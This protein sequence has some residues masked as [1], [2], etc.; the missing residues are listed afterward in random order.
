MYFVVEFVSMS[1]HTMVIQHIFTNS[2]VKFHRQFAIDVDIFIFNSN[3]SIS[4]S[5]LPF[6]YISQSQYNT[7]FSRLHISLQFYAFTFSFKY[8]MNVTQ[9]VQWLRDM[10]VKANGTKNDKAKWARV[11]Q[12]YQIVL[13]TFAN[14]YAI[15][16]RKILLASDVMTFDWC[17]AH[18]AVYDTIRF[19]IRRGANICIILPL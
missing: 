2:H 15:Q 5:S 19:W 9:Y 4:G 13:I 12:N 1:S 17:N 11:L 7:H 3:Q 18:R 6:S 10:F 8:L 16:A 14:E